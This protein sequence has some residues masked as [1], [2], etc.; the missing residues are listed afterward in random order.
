MTAIQHID[1][2]GLRL[3]GNGRRRVCLQLP[4]PGLC[5]K[6]YSLPHQLPKDVGA[7]FRLRIRLARFWR[8]FN[9]NYK[10]WRYF[11]S[12]KKRLPDDCLAVFP[13]HIA[14]AYSPSHGWG[15]VEQLLVNANGSPVRSMLAEMARTD[16]HALRA[17]FLESAIRLF[18]QM[19]VNT[20]CFFDPP[21]TLVQWLDDGSFRLR[22]ADFEPSTRTLVP[23]LS[24]VGF[25]VRSKVRRRC[26]R[27][28]SRIQRAFLQTP[29]R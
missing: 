21:N 7:K 17:R 10:E 13:Q 1:T 16:D 3:I 14:L 29:Q 9:A 23:G 26:G 20:V 6:F 19:E 25:L 22:V 24:S 11:Q 2:D 27:F 8:W 18:K 28:V 15:I 5:V 4:T 12:L